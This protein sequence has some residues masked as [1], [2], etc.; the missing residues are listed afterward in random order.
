MAIKLI[1]KGTPVELPESG[2]SPNWAPGIIESIQ[3]LTEAVNS[4]SGTYDVAPQVQ[5]ISNFGANTGINIDNLVFPSEEVRAATIFYSV[6][7]ETEA[8]DFEPSERVVEA[9]TLQIV[10]N[11]TNVVDPKWEIQR[12]FIGDAKMSFS[13][14]G[15]GQIKFSTIKLTGDAHKGILSFRA[16]SILNI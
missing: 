10:Y 15:L 8:S 14:D 2:Q 6:S 16:I 9:G 3:A 11:D 5:D 13:I 1:I 12:E 4:I 7:R